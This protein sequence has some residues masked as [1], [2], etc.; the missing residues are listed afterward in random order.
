MVRV[1]ERNLSLIFKAECLE[2]E[3]DDVHHSEEL[4]LE[5]L[6]CAE[7]VGIVLCEAAHTGKTVK[8]TTLLITVNG[9]EFCVAQ[10]KILVAAW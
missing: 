8:L 3:V 1:A 5:L 6:W 4:L 2:H 7:Q 9:T 10:R